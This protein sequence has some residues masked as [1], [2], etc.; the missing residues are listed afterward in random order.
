MYLEEHES[1]VVVVGSGMFEKIKNKKLSLTELK[2]INN[3]M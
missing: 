1:F 3:Y 2:E